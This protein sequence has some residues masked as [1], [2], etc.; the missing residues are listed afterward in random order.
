VEIGDLEE[1]RDWHGEGSPRTMVP[2]GSILLH[3]GLR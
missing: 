3:D 2:P 1:T